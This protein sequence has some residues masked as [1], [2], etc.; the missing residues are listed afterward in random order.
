[1]RFDPLDAILVCGSC[2]KLGFDVLFL[3]KAAGSGC[4]ARDHGKGP[5]V[6][7]WADGVTRH[8][9]IGSTAI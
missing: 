4:E 6:R 3:S 1:L 2:V 5:R 9:S 7:N 8:T